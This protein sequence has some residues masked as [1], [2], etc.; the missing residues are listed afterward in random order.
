MAL[1]R[2]TARRQSPGRPRVAR[3]RG[4]PAFVRTAP[5]GVNVAGYLDT[6]SGMGEAA[7]ASIRSLEAAGIPVALNN[8]ASRLRKQDAS[9]AQRLRRRQ[10]AS[11][12]PRAPERRQHGVVRRGARPRLLQVALHD[13]LLVLGAG[14]RSAR[15]GCRSS[16]TSTK[17]GPRATSCATRIAA[18]SPV[19]VVRMPLP[20]VLPPF[21]PLGRA[22]FGCPTRATVFLYVFDV[23]SQTERKNPAGAIDAFRRAGFARD[24]AVLVLKFTNAEYDREAVRRAARASRRAQRRLPRRLHGSRRAVGADRRRRLLL[25]AAPF[26]RLRPDHPRSDAPGQAGDRDGL[27]RQ[28]RLH[29]AAQQLPARLSPRRRSSATTVPTCAARRGRI[30]I[31]TRRPRLLRADRRA[32]RTRRA[33]AAKRA[34][35]QLAAERNPAATRRDR[36][37]AAR[38]AIRRGDDLE[39]I[40]RGEP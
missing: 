14:R 37:G 7:R 35:R 3:R 15:T 34:Q 36:A 29:D 16:A 17:S 27:L 20:I 33:G 1:R 8:V 32:A 19:P 9:Y 10:P 38:A 13:R 22:H 12:Q 21:P 5:L 39:A 30:P 4:V 18:W 31:S 11:V 2:L 23:S 6:E 40:R 25:L 24:E 26:R 28:P